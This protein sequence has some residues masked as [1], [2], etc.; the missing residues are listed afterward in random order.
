MFLISYM[1]T[2]KGRKRER[3]WQRSGTGLTVEPPVTESDDEAGGRLWGVWGG[4]VEVSSYCL[5][6][7][8]W[9]SCICGKIISNSNRESLLW[10]VAVSIWGFVWFLRGKVNSN[11][12]WVCSRCADFVSDSTPATRQTLNQV[13]WD[14]TFLAKIVQNVSLSY[15]DV[16][17]ICQQF[18][19]KRKQ[20]KKMQSDSG[21]LCLLSFGCC[22]LS[23]HWD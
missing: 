10:N 15:C 4:G 13:N 16:L 22:V 7:Q 5:H 12:T 21:N 11:A 3:E 23:S 1:D 17:Y 19:Q 18:L 8:W 2:K 20:K 6:V 14:W 9:S